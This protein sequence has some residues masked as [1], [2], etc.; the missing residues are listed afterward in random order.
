MAIVR[1][2]KVENYSV[3]NNYFL[4]DPSI[5]FKAKGLLAYL[6]SKP[7]D[8]Q[9]YIEHLKKTSTDGKDSI[10]S[11]IKELI[12]A[13]Y[14]S[15]DTMRNEKGQMNGYNY[16]VYEHPVNRYAVTKEVYP[17][18][19][20]PSPVKSETVKPEQANPSLLNTDVNQVFNKQN[21]DL[22]EYG[23]K[24]SADADPLTQDTEIKEKRKPFKIPTLDECEDVYCLQYW[25]IYGTKAEKSM[26][27]KYLNGEAQK[28]YDYYSA[29]GWRV[30]KNPMKDLKATIRNWIRR[31]SE[32]RR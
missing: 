8:W 18:T 28:L 22:R 19:E 21:T 26:D 12:N 4:N 15:R 17:E 11:I 1:V 16:V 25:E 5:S 30:G 7:N 32:F 2:E 23:G 31:Q 27:M 24:L 3:I 6:L 14:I 10:A 29:N 9:I 20:K 13:N